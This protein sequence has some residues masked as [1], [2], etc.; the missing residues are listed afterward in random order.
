VDFAE[1]Q[2]HKASGQA[3]VTIAGKDHYLGSWQS[4]ESRLKYERLITAWMAG[5]SAPAP[6][7]TP[8]DVTIAELCVMFLRWAKK[9]YQKD[10]KLTSE[11]VNVRRAI[12]C[13]R[14]C[15]AALPVKQFSPLK[16]KACRDRLVADGLCRSNVNRYA[17]LIT[18][19]IAYGVE[20]ELVSG[21]VWHSLQAVKPLQ[22]GRS[23]A[24][25]T[26]PI[27]PVSDDPVQAT[28][29]HLAEPYRTMVKIQCLLGCMPDELMTMTGGEVDRSEAIWIYRPKSHKTQHHGKERVSPIGPQAQL[30]L[31]PFLGHSNAATTEI[32]AEKNLGLAL[33]IAAKMG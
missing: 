1:V 10:G 30:L 9:H 8:A 28:I 14:E 4:P 18:R 13:L 27:G 7:E 21:E 22:A 17:C 11:I 5:D 32:Y 33:D 15:Y 19:I 16:L 23:E 20:N 2:V 26:S 24:R 25:E 3:V 31:R 29:P 12:R 6:E